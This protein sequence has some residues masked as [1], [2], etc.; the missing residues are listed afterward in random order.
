M[1]IPAANAGHG[2][3]WVFG[4]LWGHATAECDASEPV[5]LASRDWVSG[6]LGSVHIADWPPDLASVTNCAVFRGQS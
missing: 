3:S 4:G 6:L 5:F 1:G 2:G